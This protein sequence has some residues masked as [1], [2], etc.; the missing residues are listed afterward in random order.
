MIVTTKKGNFDKIH[1]YI[2]GEYCLTVYDTYFYESGISDGDTIDEDKLACLKGEASFRRAY[3]SALRMIAARAHS[4]KEVYMKLSRNHDNQSIDRVLEKLEEKGYIDD[5]DYANQRFIYLYNRKKWGERRIRQEL[6][7]KG[8][9]SEII[10][11]VIKK[12]IDND[13]VSR[14]IMLIDTKHSKSLTD[15]KGKRRVYSA[16]LRMGY[17]NWDIRKAFSEYELNLQNEQAD[18]F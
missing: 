5:Y 1:I 13:P 4:K 6:K 18:D 9:D 2:D 10:D 16:L 14:I 15:E 17:D 12:G 11:T 7:S 3:E 8:V